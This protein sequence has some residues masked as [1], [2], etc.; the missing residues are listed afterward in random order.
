MFIE[1]VMAEVNNY[2]EAGAP[3]TGIYTVADG[4]ITLPFVTTGQYFRVEGSIFNDGVY[5]NPSQ[6]VQDEVFTGSITPLAPP[7]AFLNL[8]DKIGEFN[9]SAAANV[10]PYTS[11]SFGGYSYTKAAG[12][13]GGGLT[14][15]EAFRVELRRW[16][17]I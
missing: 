7:K 3:R 16:R 1:E 9:E 15:Q 17:K 4:S 8:C 12:A 13:G 2:F 11:E 6:L 5:S 10:G 14:W